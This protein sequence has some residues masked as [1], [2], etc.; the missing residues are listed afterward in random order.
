M[1]YFTLNKLKTTHQA[2]DEMF[3]IGQIENG[4]P[5]Y[6]WN[7]SHWTNWKRHTK[8]WMKYFT[9]N[10][11][12]TAHQAIDEIFHIHNCWL[13]N[14]LKWRCTFSFNSNVLHFIRFWW[15]LVFFL[16]TSMQVDAWN[17]GFLRW[18]GPIFGLNLSH[19]FKV[20]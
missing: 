10:K 20:Q 13:F 14:R 3:H 19:K 5:S 9:L 11:L 17:L 15:N 1:K 8:L 6:R 7:I 18:T 4:T 16:I 2:I 12:K